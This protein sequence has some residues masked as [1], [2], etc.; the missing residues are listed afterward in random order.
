[1][2]PLVARLARSYPDRRDHAHPQHDVRR[3]ESIRTPGGRRR[4]RPSSRSSSTCLRGFRQTRPVHHPICSGPPPR[5]DGQTFQTARPCPTALPYLMTGIRIAPLRLAVIVALV[6][7]TSAA[8]RTASAPRSRPSEPSSRAALRVGLRGRRL[9]HR[10]GLLPRD[11]RCWSA[12]PRDN[13]GPDR[14][15]L[16]T[17]HIIETTKGNSA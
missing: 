12:S 3:L 17:T 13:R 6:A 2:A 7:R 15:P 11:H 1:M 14:Q 4:S 16:G 5:R 10:P 9:H 8:H